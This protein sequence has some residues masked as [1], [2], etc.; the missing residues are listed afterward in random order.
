MVLQFGTGKPALSKLAACLF[1]QARD[2]EM[3]VRIRALE[4]R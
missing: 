2:I 4:P 1:N 3:R